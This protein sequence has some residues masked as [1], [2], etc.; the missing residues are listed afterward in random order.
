LD[1]DDLVLRARQQRILRIETIYD[2]IAALYVLRAQMPDGT[3]QVETF[4]NSDA[5]QKRLEALDSQLR[6]DHWRL[7]QV[8]PM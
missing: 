3:Q 2:D 6:A 4:A 1:L 5:G 8:R 7:R